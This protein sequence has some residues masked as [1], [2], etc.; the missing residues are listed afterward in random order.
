MSKLR[1]LF[2]VPQ[3]ELAP[4]PRYRVYQFLPRLRAMGVEPTMLVAR[5]DR[6]T[7]RLLSAAPSNRARRAAGLAAAWAQ[8]HRVML[9][10]ARLAGRFDRVVIYR[11]PVPTWAGR[12]LAA[13]RDRILF[14]FDDALDQPELE[15]GALQH[16]RVRV[17]RRGLENAVRVSGLTI[18]SNNRNAE[19]VRRLGGRVIVIPTSVDVTRALPRDRAR[20]SEPAPVLGWIGTPTTARYLRDVEEAIESL[21]AKRPVAVRLVGAAGSP[22][23]RL[24]PELHAWSL[25][26]EF[27]ELAAFDV[28][29]M[30]MPDTPWTRGKAALKALQ[31]G[32]AGM[33]TV[34][35][36]T[37][38]NAEILGE[39][40]GALLCRTTGE[41]LD[42]L[43]RLLD[44]PAFRLTLG[45]RARRLV[46][47]EYSLD[48]VTP[49]LLRAIV[50]PAG[51]AVPS[52][53]LVGRP[54]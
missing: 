25:E 35:S 54:L 38:T 36:W 22:F 31:Y 49:T 20:L 9:R 48:V 44:E 21:A 37:T 23:A 40:Q 16:W 5:P 11:C 12:I 26:T 14:D 13:H 45:Q 34:A 33:P 17:L 6:A 7:A 10:L 18:T 3:G 52:A 8:N 4:G 30:P 29:L 27:D 46:E 2:V 32:A 47:A 42:A 50:N 39:R 53:R 43:T 28:G 24:R 51:D 15:G 1:T 19:V 41:W